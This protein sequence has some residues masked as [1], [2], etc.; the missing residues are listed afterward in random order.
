MAP[1]LEDPAVHA[2]GSQA[3]SSA[4]AHEVSARPQEQSQI[5]V[6]ICDHQPAYARGLAVLLTQEAPDFK[7]VGVA[8]TAP[9]ALALATKLEPQIVLIDLAMPNQDQA[10]Y[11][12]GSGSAFNPAPDQA[13][14][15][16]KIRAA[17]KGSKV[18]ALT[19]TDQP[20][21]LYL[22]IQ[23]GAQSFITKESEVWEIAEA[24]RS[25]NRAHL[26]LPDQL[27]PRLLKNITDA[28]IAHIL[29]IQQR[30]ILKGFTAGQTNKQI[31]ATLKLSERTLNRRV[32]ELYA[33][34][35]LPDRIHAAIW[36]SERGITHQ[37]EDAEFDTQPKTRAEL[38]RELR[39]RPSPLSQTSWASGPKPE[40]TTT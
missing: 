1:E 28:E 17:S 23:Q 20:T 18:V 12:A 19:V 38:L 22:A 25:V 36:A 35:N 40:G 24:L 7:V 34:L 26:V 31:A 3:Q 8:T 21:D 33:K 13:H 2:Q 15:I 29:T 10:G 27:I 30:Q 39:R 37:D 4:H 5:T 14:L 16:G 32:E 9:Q 11:G 6:I